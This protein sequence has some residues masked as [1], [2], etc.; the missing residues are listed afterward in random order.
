MNSARGM[1]WNLRFKWY[2]NETYYIIVLTHWVIVIFVYHEIAMLIMVKHVIQIL[3]FWK[4]SCDTY[5]TSIKSN[6]LSSLVSTFPQLIKNKCPKSS[7][8]LYAGKYCRSSVLVVILWYKL[9]QTSWIYHWYFD[10]NQ[11]LYIPPWVCEL[12]FFIIISV[13]MNPL[14]KTYINWPLSA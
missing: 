14:Y 13:F 11:H 2:S 6:H 5:G 1:M 3:H 7:K 10:I 8:L 12:R 9:H 4:M